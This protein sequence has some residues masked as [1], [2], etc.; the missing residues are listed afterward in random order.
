MANMTKKIGGKTEK[1]ERTAA[2]K[3]SLF[4]FFT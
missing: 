1:R 4:G 2:L 3:F